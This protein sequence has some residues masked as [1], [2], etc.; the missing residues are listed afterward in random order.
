MTEPKPRPKLT[1]YRCFC[2]PNLKNVYLKLLNDNIVHLI[3][4][5]YDTREKEPYSSAE[6][7]V[8]LAMQIIIASD[9]LI[10]VH[11]S[12]LISKDIE[13]LRKNDEYTAQWVNPAFKRKRLT[14]EL[15]LLRKHTE[16]DDNISLNLPDHGEIPVKIDDFDIRSGISTLNVSV[17]CPI[18]EENEGSNCV[19]M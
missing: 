5:I 8:A 7:R 17:S 2:I 14:R 16:I 18:P 9:H 6:I 10:P 4:Y 15:E 11:L 3:Q 19:V 13:S 1:D 12:N